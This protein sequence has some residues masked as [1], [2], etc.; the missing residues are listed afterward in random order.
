MTGVDLA[1][2]IRGHYATPIGARRQLR[3]TG[4]QDMADLAATHFRDIPQV[5]ATDGDLAVFDG[6]LGQTLGLVV[7]EMVAA[8]GI[9][10]LE[11]LP[12]NP[13]VL[14]FRVPFDGEAV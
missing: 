9:H 2:A 12:R 3:R 5:L 10:R 14:T 4:C 8:P 13:A 6:R 7:G 11:F 1:Q